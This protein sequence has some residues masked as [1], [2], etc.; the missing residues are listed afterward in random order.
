MP[1]LVVAGIAC[2]L[3]LWALGY[4]SAYA[5]TA[6]RLSGGGATRGY[7][8]VVLITV[9]AFLD[10]A[11]YAL[12]V[13]AWM[14]STHLTGT[15]LIGWGGIVTTFLW[16]LYAKGRMLFLFLLLLTIF[17]SQ[18]RRP[19]R[20]VLALQV[21]FLAL[22]VAAVLATN[23]FTAGLGRDNAQPTTLEATVGEVGYRADLTDLATAIAIR[24]SGRGAG[25]GVIRD[26]LANAIPRIFW[27]EKDAAYKD[28]YY[29][30]LDRIGFDRTDYLE[31][32]F[33]N[34]TT[35]AGYWGFALWPIVYFCLLIAAAGV[36]TIMARRMT[37]AFWPLFALSLLALRIE[38]EWEGALL[39]WRDFLTFSAML[40]CL[41][42]VAGWLAA[43]GR[44]I[45]AML[46][47]PPLSHDA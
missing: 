13:I 36:A 34:G 27:P 35:A 3:T 18:V 10:F 12:A 9:S 24:S 41:G 31:M 44:I 45:G 25:F 4:G 2:K 40:V 30:F 14:A 46:P 20:A 19:A 7:A 43:W 16:A 6:F 17:A 32:P 26:A 29:R 11:G 37:G 15:V 23:V 1:I 28:V 8:D 5:E 38:T 22:P 39:L 21:T 33:S 42:V 47:V